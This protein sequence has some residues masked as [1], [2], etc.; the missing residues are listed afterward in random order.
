MKQI[1]CYGDSNTWGY[2]GSDLVR[3][4]WE[5]RWTGRIQ[6]Q[7]GDGFRVIEEGLCSRTIAVEDRE[8]PFRS[9][10]EYLI[11]CLMSHHPLDLIIVLLGTNDT[12]CRYRLSPYEIGMEL[13]ELLKGIKETLYWMQ[14]EQTKILL[15]APARIREP[16]Q[17]N[18]EI[19]GT[20]AEKLKM[21]PSIYKEIAER[22]G[23]AFMDAGRYVSDYQPDGIHFSAQGHQ[24]FAEAVLR[25]LEEV[26]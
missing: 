13:E 24:Q 26:W 14:S 2:R 5:I 15:A 18:G 11:P 6:E 17:P 20:S 23:A 21:L 8:Q 19:D 3:Y 10:L 7:L 16:V 1:L 4:P 12:K 25:K 9:G 22:Y